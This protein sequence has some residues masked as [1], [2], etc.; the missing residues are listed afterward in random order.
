MNTVVAK[1]GEQEFLLAANLRV[2]Y[3]IQ[4]QNAHKTYIQVFF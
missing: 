4:G 1:I 3:K 2:A